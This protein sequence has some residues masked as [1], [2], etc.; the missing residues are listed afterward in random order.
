MYHMGY[1]YYVVY[2][3]ATAIDRIFNVLRVIVCAYACVSLFV[4]VVSV[5]FMCTYIRR[6]LCI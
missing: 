2:F 6:S 3:V 5:L 1:R 4:V